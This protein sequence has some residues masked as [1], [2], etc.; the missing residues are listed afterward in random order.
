MDCA[1]LHVGAAG[2]E[3]VMERCVAEH[4]SWH[5]TCWGKG[6][7]QHWPKRSQGG[8]TIVAYPCWPLHDCLDNGVALDGLRLRNDVTKRTKGRVALY[9][10]IERV[11]N[12]VMMQTEALAVVP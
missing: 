3:V 6:T 12:R 9:R 10:I 1:Y 2:G 5:V 4:Q 11:S 8:S 7:P